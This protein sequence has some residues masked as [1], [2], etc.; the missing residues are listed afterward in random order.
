MLQ[1]PNRFREFVHLR[2]RPLIVAIGTAGETACPTL[3]E[4]SIGEVGGAGGFACRW[5]LISIAIRIPKTVMHSCPIRNVPAN[6]RFQLPPFRK[7][8]FQ[9]RHQSRHLPLERL[10]I[11][12]AL[13][14]PDIP[15]LIHCRYAAET[16]LHFRARQFLLLAC[17]RP[18]TES[19]PCAHGSRPS[20]RGSSQGTR[21][22]TGSARCSL[23]HLAQRRL[24]VR[25][26][27]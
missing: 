27:A 12:V 23:S 11:L 7:L 4:Q 2:C 18:E 20:R 22:P 19:R 16:P 5:K 24:T 1:A 25:E 17:A 26:F 3:L 8:L 15:H 13:R 6:C 21:A 14:R 9:L 10:L